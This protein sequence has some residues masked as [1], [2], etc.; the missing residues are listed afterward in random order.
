MHTYTTTS[1]PTPQR[2]PTRFGWLTS[3]SNWE[4][5]NFLVMG[6][7]R[8]WD[9]VRITDSHILGVWHLRRP[10]TSA[11]MVPVRDANSGLFRATEKQQ[12]VFSN[13]CHGLVFEV[14]SKSFKCYEKP[15]KTILRLWTTTLDS[16]PAT[17]IQNLKS[18]VHSI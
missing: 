16:R 15:I 3:T 10:R 5:I 2:Y 17:F 11:L 6:L 7:F 8:R 4:L 12:K 14:E 1:N 18:N 13:E 9:R